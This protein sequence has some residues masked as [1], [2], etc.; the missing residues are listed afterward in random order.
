MRWQTNVCCSRPCGPERVRVSS[1]PSFLFP[2]FP[3]T[4]PHMALPVFYTKRPR[5]VELLAFDHTLDWEP[6]KRRADLVQG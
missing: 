2:P 1:T 4:V 6:R 5:E 3:P